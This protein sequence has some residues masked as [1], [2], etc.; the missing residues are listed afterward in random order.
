LKALPAVSFHILKHAV[1][2][3]RH[4]LLREQLA[5]RGERR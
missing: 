4:R 2:T 1:P 3:E 5:V